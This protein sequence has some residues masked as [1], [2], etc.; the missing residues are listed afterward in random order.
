MN[1]TAQASCSA[2]AV[3]MGEQGRND[4]SRGTR[5]SLSA[6]EAFI[7]LRASSPP[8]MEPPRTKPA[9]P[10]SASPSWASLLI[11]MLTPSRSLMLLSY[12][13]R[14]SRRTGAAPGTL[15]L[16]PSAPA[17]GFAAG[18]EVTG[19]PAPP[20]CGEPPGSELPSPSDIEPVHPAPIAPAPSRQTS[21]TARVIAWTSRER[22]GGAGGG[23]DPLRQKN[24]YE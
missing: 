7:T 20:G 14:V 11:D 19:P 1:F 4:P 23:H 5:L 6:A 12:S 17:P 16:S 18:P 8:V 3:G 21:L 2:A 10:D 22:R 9:L 24:R 13:S 15:A